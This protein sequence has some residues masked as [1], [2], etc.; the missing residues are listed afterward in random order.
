MKFQADQ[1]WL[2]STGL[3]TKKSVMTPDNFGCARVMIS[4]GPAQFV[5]AASG[6]TI[7][8]VEHCEVVEGYPVEA[9]QPGVEAKET[10]PEEES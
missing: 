7:G 10:R 4:A 3:T 1:Q 6:S 5:K 9:P 8:T 2:K